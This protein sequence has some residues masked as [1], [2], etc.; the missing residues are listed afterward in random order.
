MA[1]YSFPLE[2]PPG[3]LRHYN[4]NNAGW[5]GGV[6]TVTDLPDGKKIVEVH[7][8]VQDQ[9]SPMQDG[10]LITTLALAHRPESTRIGHRVKVSPNGEVRQVGPGD[11][12]GK[13][14]S[15]AVVYTV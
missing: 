9:I 10:D 5:K 7:G 2:F 13:T 1:R 6:L 3:A 14:L 11:V 12:G 4:D 15:F 8:A